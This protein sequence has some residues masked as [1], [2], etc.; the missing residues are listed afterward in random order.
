[1]KKHPVRF[2]VH[3]CDVTLRENEKRDDQLPTIESG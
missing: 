1:M 2:G 3:T